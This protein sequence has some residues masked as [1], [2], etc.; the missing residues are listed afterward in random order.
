MILKRSET[1][2]KAFTLVE[3]LVVIA[4]IGILVALLLP[5][6]QAAREAARRTH[7]KN[8][9][10]QIGVAF[11]NH[12]NT[13]GYFPSG[14]WG[15]TWT[16]DPDSGTGERQPGGWAYSLLP[17]LESVDAH[18]VGSGLTPAQKRVA[19]MEQQQQIE[20]TFYC[21]S[22]RAAAL[23]YAPYP[24]VNANDPPG[25]FVAKTDYAANGGC[26]SPAEG[27]PVPWW[28][29]PSD[30]NCINSYPNCGAWGYTRDNI[31]WFDG[32]V[33]PRYPIE[34]R[35]ILRGTTHTLLAAE[36]YLSP[37]FYDAESRSNSCADNNSLYQG[38]DWDVIRWTRRDDLYVPR[39]DTSVE[40]ACT[41]R[42]GSAHS[43]IFNGLMCDGSVQSIEY[44]IDPIVW[45]TMGVI[46]ESCK[47]T[48]NT[49]PTGPVR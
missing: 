43:S 45:E 15:W 2:R 44:D 25:F 8:Q 13:H 31:K 49:G 29:G 34:T 41:V 22:R 16:G 3:L 12:E 6:V 37:T 24:V 39:Q 4:I 18:A 17:F 42:F 47:I 11:L 32:P 28:P 5:A 19:L 1:A 26:Y 48:Q 27:S 14:G 9:L 33:R 7:C 36:K 21:P 30:L 20:P 23:S 10:H 38:Y 35:Q 40:E 46:G